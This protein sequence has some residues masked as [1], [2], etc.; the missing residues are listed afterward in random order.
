MCRLTSQL[1]TDRRQQTGLRINFPSTRVHEQ[2]AAGT[3]GIFRLAW[4]KTCLAYQRCLL[5]S[6]DSGDGDTLHRRL[7]GWPINFTA[8][9]NCRQHCCRNLEGF[10]NFAIPGKRL[11]IHELCAASVCDVSDVDATFSPA[12]QVP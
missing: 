7:L 8:G 6:E 1:V 5:I 3:V 2:E 10:K 4:L 11:E 9:A 12:S